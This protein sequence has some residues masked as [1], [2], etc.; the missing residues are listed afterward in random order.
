[1]GKR[2]VEVKRDL[3]AEL[4]WYVSIRKARTPNIGVLAEWSKETLTYQY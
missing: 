1:M 2:H 4:L 3:Q